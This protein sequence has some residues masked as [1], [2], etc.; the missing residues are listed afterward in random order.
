MLTVRPEII[1]ADI[2]KILVTT[3]FKYNPSLTSLTAGELSTLVKNTINQFDTDE[4]NGF[5]AIFRHSNLLK[6]ID[7]NDAVLSN[8]TNI[9]LRKK[10]KGTVSTNPIG[11]RVSFGNP[12]Y[13]PHSGHNATVVGL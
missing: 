12:L 11:Y 2:V 13:N 10:M 6:V 4:L 8:T 1:D 3:T 7:A 5:D 9:R